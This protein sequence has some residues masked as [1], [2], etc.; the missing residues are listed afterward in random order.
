[1]HP[2]E[3]AI[4]YQHLG[5]INSRNEPNNGQGELLAVP[6]EFLLLLQS[7]LYSWDNLNDMVGFK[8]KTI[9]TVSVFLYTYSCEDH[10]SCV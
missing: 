9:S 4:S 10:C 2:L 3:W 1:M 7:C 6:A 8:I 5:D